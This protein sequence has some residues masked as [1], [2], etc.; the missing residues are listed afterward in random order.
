MRC[1]DGITY[2]VDMS[3]GVSD[4]LG[5]LCAAGHGITKGQTQLSDRTEPGKLVS[6]VNLKR[7]RLGLLLLCFRRKLKMVVL[8]KISLKKTGSS[9]LQQFLIGCM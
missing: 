5:S 1:L 9:R 2:S 6:Q 8:N 4:G 7:E 3:L